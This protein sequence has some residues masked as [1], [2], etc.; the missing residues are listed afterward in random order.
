[1]KRFIAALLALLSTAAQAQLAVPLQPCADRPD[2]PVPAAV[3]AI[4]AA[5]YAITHG[6]APPK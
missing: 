3:A 2:L 6:G 4:M 5:L 1:M